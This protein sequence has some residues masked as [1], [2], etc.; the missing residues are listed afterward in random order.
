VRRQ[1]PSSSIV[2]STGIAPKL[3]AGVVPVTKRPATS[4]RVAE[5]VR[6]SGSFESCRLPASNTER[7]HRTY[8]RRRV[9][10]PHRAPAW[11]RTDR[12]AGAIITPT[13]GI[14]PTAGGERR[15]PQPKIAPLPLRSLPSTNDRSP[16]PAIAPL[17]PRSSTYGDAAVCAAAEAAAPVTRIAPFHRIPLTCRRCIRVVLSA[18]IVPSADGGGGINDIRPGGGGGGTIE[19]YRGV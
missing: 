12:H 17:L 1:R 16:P 4:Y 14:A 15:S 5:F 11:N 10:S 19:S 6:P 8:R 3:S 18:S 9:A 2:T 13:A 7:R